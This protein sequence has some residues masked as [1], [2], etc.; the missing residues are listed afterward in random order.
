MVARGDLGVEL[1]F[2]EVP[3]AQKRIIALAN[4]LGRPVITATQMLESMITHPRPTR[5]EASDVANAILDGTDAVMLSAETAAGAVSAAGRRG[6]DAHHSRDRDG[7]AVRSRDDRRGASRDGECPTR[8]AIAAASAAAVSMLGAPVLIVFTKSGFSARIVASQRPSVPILVLT[9]IPRTYRQLAL[10]WGVIPELVPHCDTYEADGAGGPRTSSPARPGAEGRPRRSSPPAYRSTCPA[11]PTRSR[12]RRCEAH[13]P[14]APA[15]ASAC[16][17]LGCHCAVCR[18][19][20]PRDKRTR[21]G[22]AWSRGR[23]ARGC[24]ST[25]RPNCGC[26]SSPPASTASTRCCSRTTTPT[27]RTASTTSAPSRCAATARCRSTAPTRRSPASARKFGYMFD[28]TVRPLPGTSKPEGG[29]I[30]FR[31]GESF[32]VGGVDVLPFARPARARAPSS[33]SASVTSPTSPTPRPC[34]HDV[35]EQLRRREGARASTRSSAPSTPRTS[36]SP[37]RFA[38]RARWGPNGRTS[39][40]S[41]TTTFTPIS[42]RNCRAAS[43][44]PSTASP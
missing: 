35:L 21:V 3:F 29:A 8:F 43:P 27:T 41:R 4:Q 13:V 12:W 32:V 7:S 15:R 9:D 23:A 10:V 20:D 31:H 2:E 22:R 30:V 42:K 40:T 24:C 25:R 44:R 28:E 33:A 19:A 39:R 14:R 5:A 18:S 36:A 16:P 26:S 38:W 6:D 1:P 37:R 34:P 11:R 17:Q